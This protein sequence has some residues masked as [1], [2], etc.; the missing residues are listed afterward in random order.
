M[1][2]KAWVADGA[3]AEPTDWQMSWNY[4]PTRTERGGFAGITGSSIDGVGAE[5]DYI[6]IKAACRA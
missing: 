5:V 6:L 4:I 2:A 3:E 1:F